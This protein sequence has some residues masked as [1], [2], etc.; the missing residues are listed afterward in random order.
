VKISDKTCSSVMS[1]FDII[2]Y[3][4]YWVDGRFGL[5]IQQDLI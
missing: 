4:L 5:Y 1:S 3:A 2:L